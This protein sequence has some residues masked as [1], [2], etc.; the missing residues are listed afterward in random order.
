MAVAFVCVSYMGDIYLTFYISTDDSTNNLTI[1]HSAQGEYSEFLF[2]SPYLFR[3][4]F[5]DF[6]KILCISKLLFK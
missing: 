2:Y 6:H 5:A 1:Y 4:H 3:F